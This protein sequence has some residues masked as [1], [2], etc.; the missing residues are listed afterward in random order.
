MKEEKKWIWA[1]QN[2]WSTEITGGTVNVAVPLASA[3]TRLR[4]GV[5][6]YWIFL[7]LAIPRA[8]TTFT[9]TNPN[10]AML[11]LSDYTDCNRHTALDICNCC[12]VLLETLFTI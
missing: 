5:A 11:V 1:A 9:A 2:R 7:L 6:P 10:A 12:V 8:A 4:L 3:R